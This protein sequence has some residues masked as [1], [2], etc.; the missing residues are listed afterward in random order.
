MISVAVHRIGLIGPG[1]SDWPGAQPCLRGERS[2]I[3]SPVE[4][5]APRGLPGAERR[6]VGDAVRIAMAAA[7]Q[8]FDPLPDEPAT[9]PAGTASVFASSGGDGLNCHLL[10]EALAQAQPQVS[11][12]RFT[13]SVHNAPAGY[14]S[15]ATG[16]TLAAASLSGFDGSFAA[17]LV[18]AMVQVRTDRSPVLLVA[19]DVPY[20][21]PL[22]SVRPIGASFAAALLL[23][24][25]NAR[26]PLAIL[27]LDPDAAAAGPV[28]TLADLGLERLRTLAPAA[29]AL[30]LLV[31]LARRR[32]VKLC[33]PT[34]GT[35]A[36]GLSLDWPGSHDDPTGR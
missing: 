29:R 27:S 36:L 15:I 30:P 33:I 25:V 19:Y 11:P 8:V 20:P 6:R 22:H 16:N 26:Q 28:S 7:W 10:C 14:W 5:P 18:E 2:W 3:D 12:T 17:G 1:L 13:N 31:A 4:L 35:R 24:P 9:D 34:P 21:E 32:P 23:A